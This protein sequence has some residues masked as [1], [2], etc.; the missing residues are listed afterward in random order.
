MSILPK[1]VQTPQSNQYLKLSSN[2]GEDKT[3]KKIVPVSE[4]G[5]DGHDS[6]HDHGDI[7]GQ[8]DLVIM[9]NM[10]V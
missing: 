1:E 4:L 2:Q 6:L 9:V 7:N 5:I 10:S 8:E 3:E